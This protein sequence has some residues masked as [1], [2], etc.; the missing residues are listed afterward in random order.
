MTVRFDRS[1]EKSLSKIKNKQV[2]DRIIKLIDQLEKAPDL[3]GISNVKKL[4]G[5]KSYYRVRLGDYRLV[6]EQ[7]GSEIVVLIVIAHRKDIYDNLS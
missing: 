4:K 7:Q 5:Y 2:A 3:N 1:F 6:L